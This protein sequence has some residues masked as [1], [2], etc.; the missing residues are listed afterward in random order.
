[1]IRLSASACL[2]PWV[3]RVILAYRGERSRLSSSAAS[4]LTATRPLANAGISPTHE[5][6]L[7]TA[8]L[9]IGVIEQVHDPVSER[10]PGH[11]VCAFFC[12]LSTTHRRRGHLG[13][14]RT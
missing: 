9:S 5:G 13:R 12:L 10:S 2:R 6:C 14:A 3:S 7:S 8:V 1:M 11:D 4:A